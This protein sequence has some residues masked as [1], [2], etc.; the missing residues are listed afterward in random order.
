M[1]MR[2]LQSPG[3]RYRKFK[4][5]NAVILSEV[6]RGSRQTQSKDLP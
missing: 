4:S 1:M 3:V 6:C 2:T 5:K